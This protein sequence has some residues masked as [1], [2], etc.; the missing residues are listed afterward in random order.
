MFKS[1]I[2][3][4]RGRARRHAEAYKFVKRGKVVAACD[5]DE[6]LLDPFAADFGLPAKYTDIH[7]MLDKE[8]PDLLHIVTKPNLRVPLLT[9]AHEHKVPGVIV[10][11]PLAVDNEDFRAISEIGKTTSSKMAVNHQLRY[12]PKLLELL[13]DVQDGRIGEVQ[14]IDASSRLNLAGQ[15]THVLNLV[16]AFNSGIKP[17]LVYGNVCGKGELES[18]HPAPE[19]AVA[20]INFPNRV[21]GLIANGTNAVMASD[22]EVTSHHKRIAVYGT[23]GFIHWKMEGW[24]RSTLDVDYEEGEKVY[25]EEDDLGQAA[26]TD[27]MFDWIEDDNKPHANCLDTSLA[28]TN[29]VLG[30][31]SSAIHGTPVDLPYDSTEPL[32]E[33]LAARPA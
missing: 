11:K 28:E 33:A 19:M 16:F 1:A 21:R 24:E 2:L 17:E 26:M 15:G 29:T 23:R 25:K 30:L 10:E 31:F 7:E 20:Q 5:M 14:F 9:I 27:A 8:K 13:G 6:S 32:L 12:H 18:H 3:G 22:N 4:C